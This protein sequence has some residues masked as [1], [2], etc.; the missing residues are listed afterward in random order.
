MQILSEKIT[1]II[2]D[3]H[4]V[5]RAGLRSIITPYSGCSLI[6]EA[7]DG[8]TALSLIE[9]KKPC[10]ALLDIAMP[11]LTG[12]QIARIVQ[13]RRL[14]TKLSILTVC[15]DEIIFNEAMDLGV[16]GYVLKENAAC[17][18]LKSIETVAG[19]KY[20]ISPSISGI[21]VKRMQRGELAVNTIAGFAQLT[22]AEI[23]ILKLIAGN[24]TSKEIANDL[25]VS[26]KTVENHRLNIVKKLHLCGNNAL[27]HFAIEH[28]ELF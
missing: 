19:G 3:D 8:D 22:P 25:F 2:A 21:L 23:K 24:K 11:K 28:K 1:V 10:V 17:E 6:G 12:L 9:E 26:C 7:E 4:P 27:L 18:I 13:E 15:G 5:F 20:Y 14:N 16:L